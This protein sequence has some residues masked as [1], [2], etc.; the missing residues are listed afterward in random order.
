MSTSTSLAP[1]VEQYALWVCQRAASI[2]GSFVDDTEGGPTVIITKPFRMSATEAPGQ[3]IVA[4]HENTTNLEG[5]RAQID[6]DWTQRTPRCALDGPL[7]GLTIMLGVG[8]SPEASTPPHRLRSSL[9]QMLESSI[10]TVTSLVPPESMRMCPSCGNFMVPDPTQLT[11][12][13]EGHHLKIA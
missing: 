12:E 10:R 13:G 8:S 3:L 6:Q 11:C 4:G 9:M 1:T 7:K 5:A 2:V